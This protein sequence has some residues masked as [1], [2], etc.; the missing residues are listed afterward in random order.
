[1]VLE[2]LRNL[3]QNKACVVDKLHPLLLKNCADSFDVPITLIFR[4]SL[5]SSQLPIQF[6]LANVT[7][8]FKKGDKSVS[9]NY[10]PVSL[11]SIPCKIMESII[12]AKMEDYLYKNNLLA[13][14]QHGFVKSKSCTTNLI[15]TLDFISSSLDN[16]IPVDVILFD[17][18]TN[19]ANQMLG[20]IKKSLARFDRKLFRSLY[21]TFIRPL[22]EFAVPVWSPIL[23]SDSDNIERIQHRATKLVSSIR[24]QSYESRLKALDL[25]TLVER[26]K[27]G[28]LIQMYKIMHN[29]DKVDKSNHF[30]YDSHIYELVC[31][32]DLIK[33]F[34]VYGFQ[35]YVNLK[36]FLQF[37]LLCDLIFATI[38]NAKKSFLLVDFIVKR[39]DWIK[40]M[41]NVNA[42][43]RI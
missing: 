38:W 7:P 13:K 17:F 3:D 27:R 20:R 35:L 16:G 32:Y 42:T 2:K 29:I 21:L 28:D 9:S 40:K 43:C 11:T 22:L 14:E 24:N 19:K 18:A 10:R 30:N 39:F 36:K 12:R 34:K 37:S 26:R 33:C 23:K 4:G 1:M 15:E 6:R 41:K 25:T 8:L 5:S 31:F